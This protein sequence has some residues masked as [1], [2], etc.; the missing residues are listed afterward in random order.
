MS[1]R[2]LPRNLPESNRASGVLPGCEEGQNFGSIAV[3]PTPFA[4]FDGPSGIL[5]IL[6]GKRSLRGSVRPKA[7][8]ASHATPSFSSTSQLPGQ[9]QN[10]IFCRMRSRR[11]KHPS[12]D[13]LFS[14]SG[15]DLIESAVPIADGSHGSRYLLPSDLPG[16][17]AHLD[18][19]EMERLLTAVVDEARRRG[20]LTVGLTAT[21]LEVAGKKAAASSQRR[22]FPESRGDGGSTLTIGQTNAVRASFAAGIKPST[23]ARLFGISQSE[24]KKAIAVESRSRS[25]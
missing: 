22:S 21:L 4:S 17:L 24:V 19:V 15:A 8:L 10:G 12:S 2:S 3:R 5:P 14:A 1:T 23:I 18:A 25:R 9:G 11:L 7:A 6:P 20:I 13:D 16:A